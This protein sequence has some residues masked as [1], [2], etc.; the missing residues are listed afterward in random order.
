MCEPF[1]RHAYDVEDV[2]QMVRYA[3][4][5]RVAFHRGDVE[6]RPGISLHRIGGHT[7][8]LQVVR[9]HTE[10]GWVVLASDATH[11]ADNFKRRSPF[12]IVYHV[13]E[14][15]RGYD[16][17]R[18]LADSDAHIVPG[19]DPMVLRSYPAHGPADAEIVALHASR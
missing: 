12:P 18:A 17:L 15:L 5:G 11:Y 7:D 9:V 3:Y 8:G 4:D 1:L 13:G 6:L 16:R 19:H 14:M 10:R 2:V